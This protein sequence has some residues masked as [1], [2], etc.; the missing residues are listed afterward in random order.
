MGPVFSRREETASFASPALDR[1]SRPWI[2]SECKS[3]K[4]CEKWRQDLL[5]QV[6][7]KIKEIQNGMPPRARVRGLLPPRA[8]SRSGPARAAGL[9]EIRLRE[10][11]DQINRMLREKWHW[12]EQ[13]LRLGGPNYHLVGPKMLDSDG[14][15]IKGSHGYKCVGRWPRPPGPG[16][17]M[18]MVGAC[19]RADTLARPKIFPG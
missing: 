12:D 18:G 17:L 8:H 1:G 3:I 16:P 9:G 11:N 10:L 7:K 19:V 15:E 4:E 2:A 14:K 6:A 13:I 5:S